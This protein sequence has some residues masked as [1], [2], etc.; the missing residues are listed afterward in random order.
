MK[1][2]SLFSGIGGFEQGIHTVFPDTAEC[3]GFSE[4]DKNCIS[5]Y[6]HH[7][8]DHENL[9][10]ICEIDFKPF[11]GQVDLVVGGSP[12]KDLSRARYSSTSEKKV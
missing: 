3:L 12:C 11:Y 1:Y 6:K 2:L 8:P 10:D 4:V 7:F 9:G 5:I